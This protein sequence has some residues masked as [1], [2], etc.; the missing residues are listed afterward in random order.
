MHSLRW[1]AGRTAVALV[2]IL[3]S[4]QLVDAERPEPEL[5]FSKL[6]T[7]GPETS[8]QLSEIA[9][10]D[11]RTNTI[12]VVGIVGVDVVDA[13]TGT[14][15]TH[16]DVTPHGAVNSVAIHNGLA[17]LA[18]EA[19]SQ[20]ATCPN[21]DRRNPGKVLFYDTA[22][23][24]PSGNPVSVGSLPDML[25]FTHDGSKLLVANEA[26][27]NAAADT[28]YLAVDPEGSVSIIDMGLAPSPPR[29]FRAFRHPA[30]T[31]ASHGDRHG[32]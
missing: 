3:A 31:C 29:C 17:S 5:T 32:L 18:V 20:S 1:L 21:C 10:F 19:V 30:A 27:P 16:I 28:A 23:R 24:Q 6:W 14:R 12:W 9:A 22:T 15:V 7:Y 2:L 26:T 25:T 4:D 11:P 8:G 13:G